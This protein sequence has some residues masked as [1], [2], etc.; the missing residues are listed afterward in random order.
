MDDKIK[1]LFV[2]GKEIGINGER[3]LLEVIRKAGVEIPTFCYHSEL[4][5]Y[6][7]CRL[8]IVDVEGMGIVGS[9]S[10][11]AAAGM[12]VRTATPEIREM[13]KITLELLL[14]N[15]EQ[16]CPTC[17]KNADCQLQKLAKKVGVEDVRFKAIHT[18]KPVDRT[19]PSLVR[20][21]NKCV[22]CGDCVR[23]C[24][25]VQGIGA[26]D[27]AYR[28]A[29][30]M[31]LPAFGKD[32]AEVECVNCGQC[33]R[34]CPTGALTPA[35]QTEQVWDA[36][37]DKKK[38]AVVQIAPAVRV[39]LGEMFGMNQERVTGKIVAALKRLG[40]A[41]VYD[42][43]FTADLTVIEEGNEFIARKLK[44]EKLPQFTS[45][46]PAWVKFA[47]QYYPEL[48]PNLSTCRSPQQMFGSLA[49]E[50]L[51]GTLGVTKD[52]LVVV[53]VMP[54]TAKKFEA[55]RPE[56]TAEGF[57]DVDYVL[58]TQELGRMIDEAG[59][60]FAA[61]EGESFDMPLGFRTG[62][63]VIFGV[64]GGVSEAVLRY[65]VEKISGN[66]LEN[67]VFKEVRGLEGIKEATYTIGNITVKLA[68]VH[69]LANA[70]IIAD[71]VKKGECD[72][73]LIEVMACP[74]GCIGGAGQPCSFDK[75]NI[76]EQRAK[77]LY[78]IDKNLELH[79][80]QDN[81][82]VKELYRSVLKD[83]H[84][85][86]EMLHTGYSNRKRM[87]D[88]GMPLSEDDGQGKLP[89]NVCLGT[90]CYLN[91]AQDLLHELIVYIDQNGLS[92]KVDVRGSFCF[93]K[94]SDGPVVRVG[95]E[96]I[97]HCTITK[98]IK[99]LE[100]RLVAVS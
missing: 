61:L 9:C 26:I 51:P 98:V 87:T 53:S 67:T 59:L 99:T 63:G 39:A 24:S 25:E 23:M 21:P 7:A 29:N 50:M 71:K 78:E 37:Y 73:D 91:G 55:K 76:K 31:V 57:A 11:P 66:P 97:E 79:K 47:E 95:D 60:D 64:S 44:G 49:K 17:V 45:C 74:G 93:E 88:D 84:S 34:V 40:F 16:K 15:H 54:C 90:S 65:A 18:H 89:V 100:K 58:T 33:A 36:L 94:C 5:I 62:A 1:T 85:A 96:V 14:A 27:F 30:V 83:H 77:S 20:D 42:T 68:V 8:C 41:K 3:N 32:M 22:L 12:K 72:Y 69:S 13:R 4:S 35:L 82:Y 75:E 6:G 38:T 10:T 43:S 92:N 19:S 52:N 2:D 81:P 28:G 80:A 46:C 86:H 48:L 70:R 56:F